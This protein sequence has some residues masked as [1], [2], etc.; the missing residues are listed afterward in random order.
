MA[1]LPLTVTAIDAQPG[2]LYRVTVA[3]ADFTTTNYLIPYSMATLE[4]VTISAA[5]MG[6]L[7]DPALTFRT[8]GA[9]HHRRYAPRI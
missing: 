6:T 8:S 1:K 4:A 9:H 2:G 7:L 5:A 3:F